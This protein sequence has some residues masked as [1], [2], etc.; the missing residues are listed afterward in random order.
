MP[1]GQLLT[2]PL[3]QL[4][5]LLGETREALRGR[6][7]YPDVPP[8]EP[9]IGLLGEALLD[10]TFTLST[11][12]MTG[13]P[14]PERL[15]RMLHE[16]ALARSLYEARGW[17][18][19]PASYHEEPPP[20]ETAGL[21]DEASW[22]GPRRQPFRR[23][24]FESQYAPHPEEPGRE[25][26]LDHPTNATVH[27]YVL[28]HPEP[29]PWLVCIHGF[30]MGSPFMNFAG[31]QVAHLHETLGLNLVLPVLPL[32]GPRGQ[33]RFSGGE[34][35]EPDYMKMIFLFA[36]AAWDVRRVVSW[37]RTRG[38]EEVGLYGISLGGY[39]AALVAGLE[40]ALACVIAGIPCVDF[41]NLARDNEPW[42]MRR[43]GDELRVDWS[44]VRTLSHVVSPL[45]LAPRLPKDRRFI[46]AGIADRVVHPDQPR[47]L[48]RH[49]DEPA[50]HW[51]SGGHVLGV[52]NGSTREF[53]AQSLASAG[54]D[55]ST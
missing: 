10:R 12:A 26:W 15:R 5:G 16:V 23:L 51:F 27:A 20:L 39:V 31:F 37:A 11:S 9:S 22:Y 3:Q 36:Q 8:L 44:V 53:I 43:Y 54:L 19:S 48:W 14:L 33:K 2:A 46:Y 38:G 7:R 55:R 32:H 25:R 17:L 30:G 1:L 45:A 50:I 49:W 42:I 29:R 47:A 40:D 4:D 18:A 35:L 28:E 21:A 13:V 34:V 6:S 24:V 52:M 41:P